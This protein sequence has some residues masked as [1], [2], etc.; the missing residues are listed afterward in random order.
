M[1]ICYSWFMK[2]RLSPTQEAVGPASLLTVGLLYG[3]SAV[4]A[5]YLSRFI[6][7]YQVIEYRFGIAF[8]AAILILLLSK[9]RLKFKQVDPKILT[10]FVV[11]F[12]ASAILFTLSV[13]HASV[14]LAVFSFYAAN[15]VTQFVIGKLYFNE[16]VNA[17]K[18]FAI[19]ASVASLVAFTNPFSHFAVTSG[20]AFGLVAGVLQGIASGFQKLLSGSTDKTSLLILQTFAGV[21]MATIILVLTSKS[22]IPS[23]DGFAWFS[24]I[25]FGLI[26]L[27][28]MYL[29]LVGYK[30]TNLNIGSILVSSELF[31][32]PFFAFLLLSERIAA[33][34]LIGGIF[35][36]LAAVLVS[37]PNKNRAS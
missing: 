1:P 21:I 6:N 2:Q 3:L 36:T 27:V 14:A 25:M 17:M 29:F 35:T 32:G 34:V 5:K 12:P 22:P 7:A 16:K 31:F 9:K 26:M 28:I 8:I 15:L 23:L 18:G 33:N 19:L 10:A 13:I 4:I 37:L 24:T 20:L 30:Y 11:T